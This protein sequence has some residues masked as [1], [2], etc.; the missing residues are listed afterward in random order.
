MKQFIVL[1]AVFPLLMVFLLQFSAQQ[2]TDIRIQM[3]DQAVYAACEEARTEGRFSADNVAGLRKKLSDIAHCD[4]DSVKIE[5]SEETRYRTGSYNEREMIDYHIA[6]P[7][8]GFMAMPGLF[9]I[10]DRENCLIY[11]IE[12]SVPS[13]RLM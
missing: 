5:V 10:S 3:I 7:V 1:T 4:R 8:N 9:G 13:E 11:E 12:N 6:V 2:N